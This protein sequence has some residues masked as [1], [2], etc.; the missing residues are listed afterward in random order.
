MHII[1]DESNPLDPRKNFC[2]VDDDVGNL[3]NESFQEENA[4]KPLELKGPNKEES[5]EMPQPTLKNVLPK[6]WQFKKVH[7]QDL[8]IGDST[9]GVTTRSQLKSIVNL[10]FISQIEPKNVDDALCDEFWVLAMQEELN[11]FERNKVWTLVAR[12][13]YYPIIG[14]K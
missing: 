9:K 6:D 14:S 13:K 3:M 5:E 4:S 7:P 11:Q 1:F 12:P 8:I 2:S 10:L